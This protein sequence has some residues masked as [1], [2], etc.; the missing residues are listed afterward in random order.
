M[1]YFKEDEAKETLGGTYDPKAALITSTYKYK[2]GAQYEGQWSGGMRHGKGTMVW[3]DGA[4]YEGD[5]DLNIAQ[6]QGKFTHVN[7]DVYI[8]QWKLNRING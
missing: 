5:W 3:P 4:R 2:S 8:G 6:G 1:K 7:K